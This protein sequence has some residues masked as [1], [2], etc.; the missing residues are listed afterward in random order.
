ML[1]DRAGCG[2]TK[3]IVMALLLCQLSLTNAVYWLT[4]SVHQ[5]IALTVSDQPVFMYMYIHRRSPQ[6]SY[7]RTLVYMVGID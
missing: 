5:P 2:L 4:L 7:W 6:A 1:L 3:G